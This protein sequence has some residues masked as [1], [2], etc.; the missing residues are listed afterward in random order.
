MPNLGLSCSDDRKPWVVLCSI[1]ISPSKSLRSVPVHAI[2]SHSYL[3]VSIPLNFIK[4]A[5]DTAWDHVVL[6]YHRTDPTHRQR[7]VYTWI[8][9]PNTAKLCICHLSSALQTQSVDDSAHPTDCFWTSFSQRALRDITMRPYFPRGF[10]FI[11]Y[12][13]GSMWPT[14]YYSKSQISF[15][16][17]IFTNKLILE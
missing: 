3:V 2:C 13:P 9:N 4:Q 14:F 8:A 1:R 17:K 16:W 5:T 7:W 11:K 10:P 6:L 15:H 12:T